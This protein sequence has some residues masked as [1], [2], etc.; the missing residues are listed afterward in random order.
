VKG[1]GN[2]IDIPHRLPLVTQAS[3]RANSFFQDSRLVNAFAEKN[4]VTEEYEVQQRVGLKQAPYYS[5]GVEPGLGIYNWS[6]ATPYATYPMLIQVFGPVTIIYW[7]GATTLIGT[8]FGGASGLGT[9][10]QCRFTPVPASFTHNV[11]QPSEVLAGPWLVYGNGMNT[12][13]IDMTNQWG[14]GPVPPISAAL[15]QITDGNFPNPTVP[16]IV[17]LDGTVYVMDYGG[18]IWGSTNTLAPLAWDQTTLIRAISEPDGGVAIAKQ[19]VYV[20]A[21][22]DWTTE[23]FYDAGNSPPGSPLSVVPGAMLN[24]GCFHSDSVQEIDGLLFWMTSNR[25][26]SPQILM[27]DNL[28]M[29]IMSD[30]AIERLLDGAQKTDVIYSFAFKHG[31]HRYYV[32]TDVNLNMTIV[33]DIDQK[34]WYQWT[35]PNGNYYPICSQ[36]FVQTSSAISAHLFQHASNGNTYLMDGDY[37]FPDDAGV[38]FPVDIYTPNF[39]AGVDRRKY[40]AAM[41]IN[42]DMNEGGTLQVRFNDS[43]YDPGSWSNFRNID[44]SL[45]RPII[46][47]CGT[48]RRRAYH[49]RKL[50]S[51]KYR[52]TSADLQ[53]ALG[54]L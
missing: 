28:N 42:A 33:L 34:F 7:Q 11:D 37:E 41:R 43:D 50:G 39:D 47:N 10:R 30:P 26:I 49:F 36:G 18:Q 48:F 53:M 32:L 23:F 52:L 20:I 12:W 31:G 24:Y 22:K 27:L 51:T 45:K 3:N 15:T 1:E 35:D 54:T 46:H 38:P 4:K 2:A 17:C 14:P 9:G 16:G 29:H 44:M 13:V 5:A 8:N 21:L 40:L 25:T 6:V 19:L